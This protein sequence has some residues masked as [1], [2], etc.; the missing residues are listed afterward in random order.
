MYRSDLLP[1][2]KAGLSGCNDTNDV[3]NHTFLLH[4]VIPLYSFG[5]ANAHR[6]SVAHALDEK[7]YVLEVKPVE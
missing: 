5:F 1:V 2:L 4:L 3:G 6:F 7:N